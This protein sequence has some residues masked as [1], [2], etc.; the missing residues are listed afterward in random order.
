[1]TGDREC[2]IGFPTTPYTRRRPDAPEVQVVEHAVGR[3]LAGRHAVAGVGPAIAAARR[4]DARREAGVGPS[5]GGREVGRRRASSNSG[6]RSLSV[7]T[8]TASLATSAPRLRR[9]RY[10][11]ATSRGRPVEIVSRNDDAPSPCAP[12]ESGVEPGGRLDVDVL[13]ARRLRALEDAAP[14]LFDCR[15]TA[16]PPTRPASDDHRAGVVRRAPP[17]G[18]V[19]RIV[20]RRSSTRSASARPRH[21]RRAARPSVGARPSHEQGF[22][23]S[24]RTHV[25]P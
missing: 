14:L 6:S 3:K 10:R 20:S 24:R 22:M 21:V 9:C 5:R 17:R 15:R 8:A 12:I 11:A 25:D 16:H 13:G 18:R 23:K 2:P 1:M 7:S 4:Q 19:G